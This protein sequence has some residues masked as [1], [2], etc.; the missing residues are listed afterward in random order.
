MKEQ[1]LKHK[2]AQ[3]LFWGGVSNGVQQLLSLSF[4]IYLA[5]KLNAD[6]YGLNL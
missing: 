2:T 3:G 5:R 6:D 1:S 4:G